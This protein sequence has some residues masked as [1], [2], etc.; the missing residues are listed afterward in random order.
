M[1]AD[2]ESGSKDDEQSTTTTGHEQT[3]TADNQQVD[4]IPNEDLRRARDLVVEIPSNI[5]PAEIDMKIIMPMPPTRT[6]TPK[7]VNF[8][9]I[10]SSSHIQRFLSSPSPSLSK[11]KSSF[12][13]L[14][15][16]LSF[17]SRNASST[18]NEETVLGSSSSGTRER[19][20]LARTFSLTM[21]FSPK[22]NRA[23]S[24]PVT[25][26]SCSNPESMHGENKRAVQAS[27]TRSRSVPIFNK[28]GKLQVGTF[29]RVISTTPRAKEE[30]SAKAAS[31]VVADENE[32]EGEDIP[33]EE[34]ICRICFVEL[35]LGLGLGSDTLKME[36]SC[37]GELALA[38]QEC[39]L[40]WFSIKGN[41]IC[42]VCKQEVKNLPV[43]LLRIQN[44][45]AQV[46]QGTA[47][48]MEFRYRIWQDIPYVLIIVSMVGYFC[49]LEELLIT[50]MG[51]GA[52][53][54]SLPF[55]CIL[56]LLASAAS[57]AM[58]PRGY[59]WTY[60]TIQFV[61]VVIFAHIFYSLL[62]LQALLSIATATLVGF[63]VTMCGNSIFVELF[64]WRIWQQPPSSVLQSAALSPRFITTQASDQGIGHGT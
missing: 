41:K 43:T 22:I 48:W 29:F 25:P 13:K 37:R 46:V 21:F 26:A 62:Q 16:S 61:M 5:T 3:P 51:S 44:S 47:R 49:F 17:K 64:R 50:K 11:G 54:I 15:P 45:Q 2:D 24:L 10:P 12:K 63:G 14:I 8:S 4:E 52:I 42:D 55:S 27:L 23:A 7:R 40:K 59:V 33:E 18:D 9:P 31:P 58:V 19:S 53:A 30:I 32:D 39:A 20:S 38:H 28:D 1:G 35:G 6:P 56:G 57:T 36:C 34:A 60:A